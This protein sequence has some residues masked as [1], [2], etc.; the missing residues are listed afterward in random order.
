MSLEKGNQRRTRG[1]A[2]LE[3]SMLTWVL[4]IA[5]VLGTTSIQLVPQGGGPSQNVL[6]TLL[7][8]AQIY[9]DSMYFVISLPFP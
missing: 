1:Q 8:S 9:Y 2:M 3:Y 4:V 7:N 6:E 5:L